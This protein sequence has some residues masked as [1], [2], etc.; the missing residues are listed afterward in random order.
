MT[1]PQDASVVLFLSHCEFYAAQ[2]AQNDA[3]PAQQIK[4]LAYLK[5]D[6][7]VLRVNTF[8]YVLYRLTLLQSYP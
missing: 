7:N 2:R 6:L 1:L 5:D 8:K 3:S 4:I